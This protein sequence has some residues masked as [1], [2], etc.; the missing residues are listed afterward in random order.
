DRT[1][2]SI[3]DVAAWH[4]PMFP[5]RWL[6][7]NRFLSID[8]ISNYS[9]KLLQLHG[10]AD[11]IVPLKFGKKLFDACPSTSKTFLQVPELGHND[12]WPEEFW[13]AVPAFLT[14]LKNGR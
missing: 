10:D 4:Y 11:T 13:A 8:R 12:E 1:F 2:S 5:V 6:I 9:G 14:Q 7:R 3:V